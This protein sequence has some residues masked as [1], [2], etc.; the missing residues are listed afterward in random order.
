VTAAL[1][2][3]LDAPR[4]RYRVMWRRRA[5]T[6]SGLALAVVA[7]AAWAWSRP[8]EADQVLGTLSHAVCL[9]RQAQSQ[10]ASWDTTLVLRD[11]SRA[12]LTAQAFIGGL[13]FVEFADGTTRHITS[14]RD[15]V[16]PSQLR[17]SESTQTLWITNAGSGIVPEAHVYEYDMA[18]RRLVRDLDIDPHRVPACAPSPVD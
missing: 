1:L 2:P 14:L 10:P 7:T 6:A 18:A 12:R 15:Y 8:T 17:W 13:V 4:Q 11:G 5:W 9:E 16:Y 3:P